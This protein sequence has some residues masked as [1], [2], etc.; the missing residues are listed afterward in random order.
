MATEP[1]KHDLPKP[2]GEPVGD[3]FPK[4]EDV[5]KPPEGS[6]QDDVKE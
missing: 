1:E 4:E 3:G 6:D 5:S 2:P